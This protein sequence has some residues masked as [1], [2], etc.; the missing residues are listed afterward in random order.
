MKSSGKVWP[1]AGQLAATLTNV[2]PCPEGG[3]AEQNVGRSHTVEFLLG[4]SLRSLVG[5]GMCS[6]DQYAYLQLHLYG[7]FYG[8]ID[9]VMLFII[10]SFGFLD[11]SYAYDTRRYHL[12]F[13]YAFHALMCSPDI[14]WEQHMAG[15]VFWHGI[16]LESW[17]CNLHCD[18]RIMILSWDPQTCLDYKSLRIPV[19]VDSRSD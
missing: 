2:M 13:L 1:G 11:L 4:T 14:R 15:Y 9:P 7:K 5:Y 17:Y 19:T 6:R 10:R 12:C 18:H 16:Q 3:S 8:I